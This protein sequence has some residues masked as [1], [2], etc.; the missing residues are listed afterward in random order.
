MELVPLSISSKITKKYA[1]KTGTTDTDHLIFGYNPEIVLGIWSGYDNNDDTYPE[2]STN[3]KLAWIDTIENYF[4]KN[5]ATWYKKPDNIVGVPVNPI[6]GE[7]NTNK[8]TI[9]YYIKG[10]EPTTNNE[11]DEFI[12]T[13]KE[14]T[15]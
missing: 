2:V 9:L 14:E 13:L 5:K 3:I 6:T 15:N 8:N 7:L 10:T 4:K 1:I 12:P 11:L